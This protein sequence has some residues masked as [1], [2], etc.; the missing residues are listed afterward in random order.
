[1]KKISV[2][3]FVIMT[4]IVLN[5]IM[6]MLAEAWAKCGQILFEIAIIFYFCEQPKKYFYRLNSWNIAILS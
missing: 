3:L 1:M 5:L 4:T 6:G 2:K